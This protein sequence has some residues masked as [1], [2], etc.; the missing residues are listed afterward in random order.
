MMKE[1]IIRHSPLI[2]LI[3]VVLTIILLRPV[4]APEV[5][6]TS[7]CVTKLGCVEGLPDIDTCKSY[8]GGDGLPDEYAYDYFFEPQNNVPDACLQGCCKLISDFSQEMAKVTCVAEQGI[9]TEGDCS[10]SDNILCLEGETDCFCAGVK[11]TSDTNKYCCVNEKG[12]LAAHDGVCD[13][14]GGI[15]NDD[16]NDLISLCGDGVWQYDQGE[17]CDYSGDE[18]A[19]QGSC[20]LV[21]DNPCTQNC[22]CAVSEVDIIN[23]DGFCFSEED[24]DCGELR[25]CEGLDSLGLTAQ[26]TNNYDGT[27]TV[28][29]SWD[30]DVCDELFESIAVVVIDLDDSSQQAVNNLNA[31][32]WAFSVTEGH[33]YTVLLTAYFGSGSIEVT[34]QPDPFTVRGEECLSDAVSFCVSGTQYSYCSDADAAGDANSNVD[35]VYTCPAE[36][37]SCIDT[38]TGAVCVF[39]V[40]CSSCNGA[41]DSF[42]EVI[43]DDVN[44]DIPYLG[45]LSCSE[46]ESRGREAGDPP[47]YCFLDADNSASYLYKSCLDINKCSDYKSQG[48]CGDNNVLCGL[49][50]SCAWYEGAGCINTDEPADDCGSLTQ[51]E[52]GQVDLCEYL[53]GECKSRD[54][55][56][57]DDLLTWSECLGGGVTGWSMNADHSARTISNNEY[58]LTKCQWRDFGAGEACRKNADDDD[59]PEYDTDMTDP[60]TTLLY[61]PD[62]E[63]YNEVIIPYIV[64]EQVTATYTKL[65]PGGCGPSAPETGFTPAGKDPQEIVID[66]SGSQE[67]EYCLWYYSEDVNHNLEVTRP[68]PIKANNIDLELISLDIDESPWPEQETTTIDV[69]FTL[70]RTAICNATLTQIKE[71]GSSIVYDPKLIEGYADAFGVF[72]FRDLPN[73]NYEYLIECTTIEG[74]PLSHTESLNLDTDTRIDNIIPLSGTYHANTLLLMGLDAIKVGSYDTVC[75][76]YDGVWTAFSNKFSVSDDY[77]GF[78]EPLPSADSMFY[79]YPVRCDFGSGW[80]YGGESDNIIFAIDDQYPVMNVT[81]TTNNGD[82]QVIVGPEVPIYDDNTIRL[83]CSDKLITGFGSDWEFGGCERYQLQDDGTESLIQD[84]IGFGV[85]DKI[86]II[87]EDSGG[88]RAPV[89]NLIGIEPGKIILPE[90]NLNGVVDN[91][92][93]CDGSDLNGESCES[94]GFEGGVLACDDLCRFD[95]SGCYGGPGYQPTDISGPEKPLF[96]VVS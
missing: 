83:P 55:V 76:Y 20:D 18:I 16:N 77:F 79:S 89:R 21:L 86:S 2:V 68:A 39:E 93:F 92:E 25:T 54:S 34:A 66:I 65:I 32:E 96:E 71:D 13:T 56:A 36:A 10:A 1:R 69:S 27:A 53:D 23:D 85:G 40:D 41:Y 19:K 9:F 3:T 7:Y 49:D 61:D 82:E 11:I 72:K 26:V 29:A 74:V 70:S 24:I 4:I 15:I 33:Q 46:V 80:V 14:G 35:G 5:T 58:G 48:T 91:D 62:Y 67:T 75:E 43:G 6:F 42:G 64:S 57:C 31:K 78:T 37:P 59:T 12:E 45:S 84:N 60:I 51:D 47:T 17:V 88:N 63:F 81:V 94:L 30:T 44:I 38:E 22:R 50:A 90:C 87:A 8:G 95:M 73:G 28:S 52:C